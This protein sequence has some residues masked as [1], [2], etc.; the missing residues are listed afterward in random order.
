MATIID[1]YK[2]ATPATGKVDLKGKDIEPIGFENTF[3]P[4]KD[5]AKNEPRLKKARGGDLSTK[6]Y[7]DS[8]NR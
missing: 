2:K 7:S 3:K 5:L 6:K 8:V 4:S 1:I